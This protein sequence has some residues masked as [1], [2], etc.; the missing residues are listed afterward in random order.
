[1]RGEL[2]MV[3]AD[4]EAQREAWS[5]GG[6]GGDCSGVVRRTGGSGACWR[7]RREPPFRLVAELRGLG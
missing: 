5:C 2:G 6:L 3:V 1:M 7:R 4:D